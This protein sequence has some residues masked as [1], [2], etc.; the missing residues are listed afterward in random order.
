V[1]GPRPPGQSRAGAHSTSCLNHSGDQPH[2]ACGSHL[3]FSLACRVLT[4]NDEFCRRNL[5][6][7]HAIIGDGLLTKWFGRLWGIA[8]EAVAAEFRA[9][10]FADQAES[11]RAARYLFVYGQSEASRDRGFAVRGDPVPTAGGAGDGPGRTG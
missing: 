10:G 11:A 8:P 2:A 4:Y 5:W 7:S 9:R 3:R 1:K 6:F